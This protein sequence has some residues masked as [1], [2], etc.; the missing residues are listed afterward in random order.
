[1]MKLA[2]LLL[3]INELLKQTKIDFIS[4]KGTIMVNQIYDDLSKRQ[5]GN[6]DIL[7]RECGLEKAIELLAG[8]GYK[9]IDE[10]FVKDAGN[11]RLF[12]L[13]KN[14]IRFSHHNNHVI[15]ELHWS[16]S[17]Y[18]VS[19]NTQKIFQQSVPAH[20]MGKDFWTM[21]LHFLF[22]FFMCVRHLSRV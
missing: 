16:L 20:F 7:I 12:L 4:Y 5:T 6:L 3:Q 15:L 21:P 2:A 8:A 10:Y 18:F 9:L 13:R 17:K 19:F 11:W 1:M 14:H 22:V